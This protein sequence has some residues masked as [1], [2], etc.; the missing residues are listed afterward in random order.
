MKFNSAFLLQRIPDTVSC[1]SDCMTSSQ[2][3]VDAVLHV[4]QV[5]QRAHFRKR[6]VGGR[7]RAV[8]FGRDF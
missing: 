1:S 2:Q 5:Q 6:H 3:W 7:A 4:G 8:L